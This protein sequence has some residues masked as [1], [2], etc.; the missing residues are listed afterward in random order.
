MR[1]AHSRPKGSLHEILCRI[2]F[3]SDRHNGTGPRRAAFPFAA[4]HR[5]RSWPITSLRHRHL[6]HCK[7]IARSLLRQARRPSARIARFRPYTSWNVQSIIGTQPHSQM[8]REIYNGSSISLSCSKHWLMILHN[9]RRKKILS[10]YRLLSPRK[11]HRAAKC[12]RSGTVRARL[13]SRG[14]LP[15]VFS[16]PAPRSQSTS[17]DQQRTAPRFGAEAVPPHD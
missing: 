7:S 11:M 13:R 14:S 9:G 3:G 2:R 5:G 8:T 6:P 17:L 1:C 15:T 10:H 12:T 16:R 4:P